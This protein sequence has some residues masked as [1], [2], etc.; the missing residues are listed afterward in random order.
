MLLRSVTVNV[1]EIFCIWHVIA[2]NA[3]GSVGYEVTVLYENV[4][5]V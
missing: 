4:S 2:I 3:V 5:A 1:F